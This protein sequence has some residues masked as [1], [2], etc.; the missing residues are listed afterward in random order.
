MPEKLGS[1]YP[2]LRVLMET[3]TERERERERER[4]GRAGRQ[5]R[6]VKKEGRNFILFAEVF[7]FSRHGFRD[8][9]MPLV[10]SHHEYGR[11]GV[12]KLWGREEEKKKE[13]SEWTRKKQKE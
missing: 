1:C 2:Q 10:V 13:K 9:G 5:E 4:E 8:V 3:P 12:T 6:E 7:G 11:P